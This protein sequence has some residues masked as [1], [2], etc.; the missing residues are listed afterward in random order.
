MYPKKK[1]FAS[2][3]DFRNTNDSACHKIPFQKP[4]DLNISDDGT[5][6]FNYIYSK[7]PCAGK[8]GD[9]KIK[10]VDNTKMLGNLAH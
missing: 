8:V 1:D 9:N 2:F 5:D 10:F 6:V 4:T 7:A 3:L